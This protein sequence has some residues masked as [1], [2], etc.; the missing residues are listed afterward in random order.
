[1][2][3][4]TI[5]YKEEYEKLKEEMET[6]K[7]RYYKARNEGIKR[8]SYAALLSGNKA[9]MA[10]RKLSVKAGREDPFSKLRPVLSQAEAGILYNIDNRYYKGDHLVIRGRA[11]EPIDFS[12]DGNGSGTW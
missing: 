2:S 11:S 8:G 3:Q 7:E 1:M 12:P 9:M 4:D 6:L 5:N 10:Y